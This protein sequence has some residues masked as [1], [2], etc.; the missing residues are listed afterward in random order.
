LIL[1]INNIEISC[2]YQLFLAL[3]KAAKEKFGRILK[4]IK[5]TILLVDQT[6]LSGIN[7]VGSQMMLKNSSTKGLATD[8]YRVKFK[9]N[10]TFRNT[11]FGSHASF[12]DSRF[13]ATTNFP[14][15]HGKIGENVYLIGGNVYL[16][17]VDFYG[18]SFNTLNFTN[19]QFLEKTNFENCI[20]NVFLSIFYTPDH[21]LQAAIFHKKK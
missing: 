5:L 21:S 4:F 9:K 11:S 20:F 3:L 15:S 14:V 8:R 10:V 17:G 19:R 12:K 2:Y 13:Y 1:K 18:C 16:N 7:Q 6:T